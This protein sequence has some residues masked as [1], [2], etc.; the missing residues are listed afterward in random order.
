MRNALT[1]DNKAA[2][3]LVLP[4]QARGVE[5]TKPFASDRFLH[6]LEPSS[7]SNQICAISIRLNRL[8]E[9]APIE[10]QELCHELYM[11][12]PVSDIA[13][14]GSH[15][16]SLVDASFSNHGHRSTR[17]YLPAEPCE[18]QILV[19]FDKVKNNHGVKEGTRARYI[20]RHFER[21]RGKTR[22]RK[23]ARQAGSLHVTHPRAGRQ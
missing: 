11:A 12:A 2:S 22:R 21:T 20:D 18:G 16:V 23:A 13:F 7:Q 8:R 14:A 6:S 17:S 9:N 15:T 10:P 1:S 5:C 3:L 19:A 4:N